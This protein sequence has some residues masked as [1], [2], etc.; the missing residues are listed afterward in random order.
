MNK[1]TG[2][3]LLS[4]LG[5]II[6]ISFQALSMLMGKAEGWSNISIT[7]MMGVDSIDWVQRIPWGQVQA[8]FNY[9]FTMPLYLLLLILGGIL[10]FIGFFF[11]E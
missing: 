8:G 10:I 5:S 2:L 9:I 11:K 4:W 7:H 1:I 3:A 6:V